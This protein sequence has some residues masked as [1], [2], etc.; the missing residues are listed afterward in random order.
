MAVGTGLTGAVAYLFKL[1]MTLSAKQ[2]EMGEQL[3]EFRGRQEGVSA[4]AAQVLEAVSNLTVAATPESS[5][6]H[7]SQG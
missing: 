5:A 1:V 3:G 6:E 7:H 4:L 2:S